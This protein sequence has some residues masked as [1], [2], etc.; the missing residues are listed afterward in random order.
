M[1]KVVLFPYYVAL[2]FRHFCYDK[3]IFKSYSFD[4]PIIIVGN[5]S[6]G[7]TGKTPHTEF[8][9]KHLTEYGQV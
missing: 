3:G 7:G 9:V 8:L 5:V 1:N 6:A 2:K 4:I